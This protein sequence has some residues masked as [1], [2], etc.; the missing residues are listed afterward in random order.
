MPFNPDEPR[1][2]DGRWSSGLMD[3]LIHQLKVKGHSP[4]KAHD[5]AIEIMLNQGLLD[6][7]TGDLTPLGK[8]REGMGRAGRRI[9]R[10]AKQLG[11]HPSELVYRNGKAVV[12]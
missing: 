10:A 9:D 4:D 12:K 7:R 8:V 2:P 6:R 1:G 5:L 3:S 11:R